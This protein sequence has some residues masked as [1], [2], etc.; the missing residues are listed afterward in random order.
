M[1]CPCGS[2]INFSDCCGPYLSGIKQAPT[3]EALMRSRYT[4]HV[5]GAF[6]YLRETLAPESRHDYDENSVKEWATKAEWLGLKVVSTKHGRENDKKGTVEFSAKY[7]TSDKVF[8]HHETS[9]FRKTLEGRWL[10]VSGDAHT[11]ENGQG[12]HHHEPVAPVVREGLKTGRNDPCPCGS[13]KKFK[14]CHGS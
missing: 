8:E 3:A 2:E 7:K 9:Q 11:H 14:K 4:A 6:D 1:T 10:F 12:H 13:G 5:R